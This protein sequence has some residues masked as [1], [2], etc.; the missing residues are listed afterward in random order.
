MSVHDAIAWEYPGARWWKFDF[1]THTPASTDYKDSDTTPHDWL[2]GFMGAGI[3]CVAITDHNS[4]DW[5]DRLKE[6]LSELRDSQ[7]PEFRPLHLYPGVEI[8]ANGNTHVLAI[9]DPDKATSDIDRL[10]GAVKYQGERGESRRAAD[11]SVIEVIAEIVKAG[12]VAIPAHVDQS[13][14]LW[15]LS[16][17]SLEPVLTGGELLAVEVADSSTAPPHLYKQHGTNLAEVLGSDSHRLSGTTEQRQPGS[18]FTWVKMEE[19]TIEGLR[20]ALHDGKRFSIRRSDDHEPH[21]PPSLPDLYVRSIEIDQARLM[22][23]GSAAKL[24]FSPWFNVLIGGRGTGKSTVLHSV[25]LAARRESDLQRL[26][27]SSDALRTF[28][29]FSQVPK[30]QNDVGGLRKETR[31]EWTLSRHGAMYRVHWC[32]QPE[33]GAVLV[34]EGTGGIEWFPSE[35]QQVN[36]ERFP[37]RLF[38]QGQIAELADDNQAALLELIDEGARAGDARRAIEEARQAYMNLRFRIREIDQQL[39]RR[40]EVT[41]RLEDNQ[42]QLTVFEDTGQAEIFEAYRRG[43]RQQRELNRHFDLAAQAAR[44]IG[45][46]AEQIQP[47]EIAEDIF[48]GSDSSESDAIAAIEETRQAVRRTSGKLLEVAEELLEVVNQQ[49]SALADSAWQ[50]ELNA[51]QRDHDAIAEEHGGSDLADP[52]QHTILVQ[53]RQQLMDERANLDSLQEERGRL[54]EQSKRD[55]AELAQARRNLSETRLRF[56]ENTLAE[57]E[58]VRIRLIPYGEDPNTTVQ[59]LR[60]VLGVEDSRF[61]D[62]IG[63]SDSALPGKGIVGDLLNDLPEEHLV[64]QEELESR[65]DK[66]RAEFSE[67]CVG[68]S[69]FKGQFNNFLK[70]EHQRSPEYLDRLNTWFP[71]DSLQVEH[72][73]VG[74]GTEF[75]PIGQGSAGQRAAAILAFLLAYGDEPLVLDQPEDDLDNQLIYDL[76]VR[77]IRENKLRRQIIAVTHNPNIVVNGDAEMVH[78]LGFGNGQCRVQ[79]SHSLQHPEVREQVC[80]VMEGGRE[81]L[82]RRYRRLDAGSGDV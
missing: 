55:Q 63:D 78:V 28:E 46:I 79:H 36:E 82:E 32:Q 22:G 75:R 71:P 45:D 57:N 50:H 9:L 35:A 51:V 56:L 25:R 11:A 61:G 12:G 39:A 17:N 38:S 73:L 59:S 80:L 72:R 42:R 44:R 76:I 16:G 15:K 66:L 53:E 49:R 1:H 81:A 4:G 6:A 52:A 33:E 68:K 69:V 34:E 13:S 47:D 37:I 74:D 30:N 41:V 8:T 19:P 77:Q 23:N 26:G 40:D 2:L 43:E 3:D 18:H 24:E 60:E 62:D 10:L 67:A 65:L 48:D 27:E 64:R 14:G 20:L 7:H 58:F 29:R 5:V 31:V 54:I 21:N 70:R